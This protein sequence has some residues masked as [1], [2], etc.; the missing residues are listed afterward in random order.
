MGQQ[1]QRNHQTTTTTTRITNTGSELKL[2]EGNRDDEGA[3]LVELPDGTWAPRVALY[4]KYVDLGPQYQVPDPEKGPLERRVSVQFLDALFSDEINEED[5]AYWFTCPPGGWDIERKV[6]LKAKAVDVPKAQR[7]LRPADEPSAATRRP[8]LSLKVGEVL[9]GTVCGMALATGV[10]VDVGARYNGLLPVKS[11]FHAW[12]KG[13]KGKLRMGDRCRVRVA[14]VIRAPLC[15]FPL[16]LEIVGED[17]ILDAFVPTEEYHGAFD[18]RGAPDSNNPDLRGT[19]LAEVMDSLTGG[20][21]SGGADYEIAAVPVTTGGAPK[22]N[23]VDAHRRALDVEVDEWLEKAGLEAKARAATR[24]KQQ[25]SASSSFDDEEGGDG[26]ER[27]R[28]SGGGGAASASGGDDTASE[29]DEDSSG[30]HR[31]R[32]RRRHDDDDE[33]LPG[34]FLEEGVEHS[35]LDGAIAGLW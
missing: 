6:L 15:R 23:M 10:H 29:T 2:Q 14:K 3:E 7:G 31:G 11:D 25:Q 4:E 34:M 9:E 12:N 26:E 32:R 21:W 18:L 24:A 1:Q 13:L 35:D 17:D 33:P 8:L 16:V 27:R 22:G 19:E 20:A 5:K 30:P 28:R